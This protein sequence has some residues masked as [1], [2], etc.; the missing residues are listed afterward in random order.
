MQLLT[1]YLVNCQEERF[2]KHSWGPSNLVVQQSD[3]VQANPGLVALNQQAQYAIP[4]GQYAGNWWGMA[5]AIGTGI[6]NL[7][8]NA[9]DAD[10]KAILETYAG[11]LDSLLG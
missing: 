1:I 9:S 7:A 4:Q 11:G 5:A 6:D 8:A 3:A 10:L 2:E